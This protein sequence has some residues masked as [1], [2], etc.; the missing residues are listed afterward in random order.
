MTTKLYKVTATGAM[1]TWML[2]QLPKSGELI[3]TYGQLDGQLQS[4][5]E[6]VE[7]NMS[8]RSL[9]EQV[10]LRAESRINK[11]LDK[12]YCYSIEEAREHVGLNASGL[13]KPMLA[14]KFSTIKNFDWKDYFIQKKYNGHRC[15]VVNQGGELYA[16]SRNG[17]P[18]VTIEHILKHIKIPVGTTLD[19]ELYIHGAP[20]QKISSIVRKVQQDNVKLTYVVYDTILA[21]KYSTRLN[22]LKG[23]VFGPNVLVAPTLYSE[24][25]HIG[26]I[27][28]QLAVSIRD[29]YEGLI[30]RDNATYYEVGKRSHSLIKVK[31][32]MD[33]EFEVVDIVPSA[34]GW[35]ILV[36]LVRP[37]VTFRVSAPGTIQNKAYMLNNKHEFIGDNVTVEFFEW[38]EDG[39]PF[40]P[41]ALQIRNEE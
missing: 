21:A 26:T 2:E 3:I 6:Y 14:Q 22:T 4:Q 19:G 27:A 30:L 38:T 9:P 13:I 25:K 5:T 7:T 29:G 24:D 31:Q 17:K 37:G 15:L 20:L 18:I 28:E 1:Q 39:V 8:G 35:G 33:K 11:Q 16:Y 34:D 41:V 40:H 23:W 32:A 36:C 10:L 12:G